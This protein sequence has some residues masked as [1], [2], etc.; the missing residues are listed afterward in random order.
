MNGIDLLK[1][2]TEALNKEIEIIKERLKIHN[3]AISKLIIKLEHESDD[4]SLLIAS[5]SKE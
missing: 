2:K 4:S 1:E 5:T 3:Q